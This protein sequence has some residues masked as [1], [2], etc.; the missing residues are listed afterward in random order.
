[1]LESDSD[2]P[3]KEA[4]Y[5]RTAK[6]PKRNKHNREYCESFE[7]KR[8]YFSLDQKPENRIQKADS[9]AADMF[10]AAKRAAQGAVANG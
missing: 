4:V 10:A 7:D 9:V 3:F 8:R 6:S 5:Y 2:T 1:M